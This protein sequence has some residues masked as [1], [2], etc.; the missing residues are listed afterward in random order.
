MPRPPKA[1]AAPAPAP[2]VLPA[3]ASRIEAAQ[4]AALTAAE[5]DDVFA[6]GID[7]GRLEALDFVATVATSALLSIFENVKK[8]KAWKHLRHP[9]SGDGRHFSSLEEFCEIKLGK[10]YRRFRELAANRNLIGQ[11]AFEQ[12]ERIGLR[13]VDYKAIRALPAPEQELVRRA[14]EESA[15]RDE[16]LGLLQEL[17]A[18]SAQKEQELRA[19]VRQEQQERAATEQRLSVVR[20]QK[21]QA[22]E[23]AALIATLPPDE[24]LQQ[25]RQEAAALAAQAEGLVLGSL[26]QALLALEDHAVSD[27]EG[28]AGSAAFMAGLL[29]QV[30]AQLDALRAEFGL[31]DAA[32]A[33]ADA[34]W[35]P[36]AEV[37][38]ALGAGGDG[39]SIID[40]G[41]DG[42]ADGDADGDAPVSFQ[43]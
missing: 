6:A 41:T 14:V 22:E 15:S 39:R 23:K 16:V 19:Q 42:G 17:A 13:Q 30:Q 12:A 9:Q 36:P 34:A 25:L 8:S 27:G 35:M 1:P 3:V 2:E 28:T 31:P 20:Q 18:R 32:D 40:M 5:T 26:R 7:V 24:K 38:A 21:E 37:L 10:S 33:D 11:Q 29:A 4:D 43:A